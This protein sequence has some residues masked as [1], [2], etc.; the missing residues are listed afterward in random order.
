MKLKQWLTIWLEKYQKN[1]IK[2]R[3]YSSY[4]S[5]ISIH[6]NPLLGDYKSN[7]LNSSILQDY[8]NSKI[9]H[10]NLINGKWLS[11]NS[12]LAIAS[13]LKN[14]LK[15]ALKLDL[16]EKDCFS[17]L[18]VPCLKQKEIDAFS[19]KDQKKIEGYCLSLKKDNH[20]GIIL[21]LYTGIRI[22]E[23]LSLTWNDIDFKKRLLNIRHTLTRF[24]Q[25]EQIVTL[26]D[27]PKTRKSKR[28]I[29]I[30]PTLISYLKVIKNRSKSTYVISTRTNS[31]VSIRNYQR[32]Y[33][34]LLKKYN[35]NYKNFHA[36]R[37]TFAT[38]ALESGIDIKTLSE[39][40]G[41]TSAT[42]TLNRYA[43]SMLNYKIMMM[44]KL[45]KLLV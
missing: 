13:I 11:T 4:Q 25:N 9:D 45:G 23:L 18:S 21:C 41:H 28:I 35:V 12:I 1:T 16:I 43:H 44:D 6:I 8:I 34:R 3:T 22:G 38:R 19:I 14:S 29:P 7:Q 26:L 36:L 37:H 39:L 31:F 20:F 5:L 32:T 30:S 40:L 42:I 2:I 27:E 33:K 10:G 17:K 24:K 15:L